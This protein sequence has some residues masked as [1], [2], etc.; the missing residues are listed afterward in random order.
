[1]LV[2][3]AT[4]RFDACK[5]REANGQIKQFMHDLPNVKQDCDWLEEAIS[6]YGKI[7]F[8]PNDMFKM[9]DGPDWSTVDKTKKQLFK[10][11][12][13]SK[14]KRTLVTYVFAGHGM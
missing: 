8:G 2:E 5:K 14:D 4:S 10:M 7:D 12:K 13:E 9:T 3:F 1:M 6:K 11:L